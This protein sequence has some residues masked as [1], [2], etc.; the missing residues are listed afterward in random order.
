MSGV[1]PPDCAFRALTA[2]AVLFTTV[3]L[4]GMTELMLAILSTS[5]PVPFVFTK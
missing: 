1:S 3:I 4:P 5:N 2:S